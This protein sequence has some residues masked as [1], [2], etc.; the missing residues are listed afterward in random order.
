MAMRDERYL[1]KA[2]QYQEVHSRGRSW[3]SQAVVLRVVPNGLQFSRYGFSISRRVGKAV[4][5][6]RV[7]RRFREI[8][9]PK[10]LSPGYDMV[11]VARVAAADSS[12][13]LLEQS[14]HNLLIR[15]R[16]LDDGSGRCD[17]TAAQGQ[18]G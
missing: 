16:V 18:S 17:Q 2:R 3:A 13:A 6:N 15:A 9:R 4:V 5:R 8:M 1:T 11:I 7:K 10:R 14:V 12:F